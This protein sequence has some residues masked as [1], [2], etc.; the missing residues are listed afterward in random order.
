MTQVWDEPFTGTGYVETWSIGEDVQAGNTLDEDFASSGVTGASIPGLAGNCLRVL[1]ANVNACMVSHDLGTGNGITDTWFR[2]YLVVKTVSTTSTQ[3]GGIMVGIPEDT[4][5]E[6]VR[7]AV[8]SKNSGAD[9]NFTM[10]VNDTGSLSAF[11]TIN[12]VLNTQ[13]LIEF[14]Y[15]T[16]NNLWE[17]RVDGVSRASGALSSTHPTDVRKWRL[18]SL[19]TSN[20]GANEVFIDNFG[21]DDADWLGP[22]SNALLT[23]QQ[24]DQFNGGTL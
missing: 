15:D 11:D 1:T 3:T 2:F 22:I 8:K 12:F 19:F 16:T 21:I 7:L 18:G 13:Y 23:M 17:F 24:M 20:T 10:D 4:G 5:I 14:K 6:V 9:F